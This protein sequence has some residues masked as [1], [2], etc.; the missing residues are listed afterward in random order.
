[1]QNS[2]K[3]C[4]PFRK[5]IT[6]SK[7]QCPKTPEKEVHIRRVLYA[8]AV[9]S[10]KY[11]MLCTRLDICYVVGIIC[12]YQSNSGPEHWNVVKHILKYSNRT[13]N[14]MLV[15]SGEDLTPTRYTNSD[16]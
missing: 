16:F 3:R 15:Y 9:G 5:G 6:L 2:K 14:H 7:D 4:I 10:L 12:R 11:S 13:K 1:M 8:S